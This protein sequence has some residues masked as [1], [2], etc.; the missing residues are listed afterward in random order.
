MDELITADA[1][2]VTDYLRLVYGMMAKYVRPEDKVAEICTRHDRGTISPKII[3]HAIWT[4]VDKD[5]RRPGLSL[6]A[7][8]RELPRC[9]VLLS[10]AILHH[11]PPGSIPKLIA[12]LCKRTNRLL[13]LSGPNADVVPDLIGDHRYHIV[14]GEIVDLARKNKFHLVTSRRVGLSAPYSEILM[15]FRHDS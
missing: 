7:V 5:K 9:D 8:H 13:M 10:T 3:P 12:N 6:D 1:A 2:R 14:P 11:T 4:N 15:V